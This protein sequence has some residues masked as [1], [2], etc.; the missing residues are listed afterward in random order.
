[1]NRK[2]VLRHW[3]G[4]GRAKIPG[5]GTRHPLF[6]LLLVPIADIEPTERRG[7]ASG[8]LRL[9]HELPPGVQ[10]L[11][12]AWQREEGEARAGNALEFSQLCFH[13][14]VESL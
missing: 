12:P 5:S 6:L 2:A 9:T 3:Q 14:S 7:T 8:A 10:E 4:L 11:P 13:S 1:M